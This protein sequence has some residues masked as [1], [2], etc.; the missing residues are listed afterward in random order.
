MSTKT[1]NAIAVLMLLLAMGWVAGAV[2]A[3]TKRSA[4]QGPSALAVLPDQSVWI[5]VEDAMWHLDA[6]GKR[7]KVVDA[8]ALGVGGMIGNLVVHPNGQLVAQTRSDPTLY[9]LDAETALIKS[10]L[11]PQWQA[12]LERHG[13]DAINYAFHDDGRVA[14]ATGGGHAVALF[15]AQGHFLART[16]PGTYEFANGLW[17]VADTLW[18][19]DTNRQELVELDGNT[20]A[21]KSR[22]PL[23]RNCGGFQYLGFAAPSHGQPSAETKS[24]PLITL[25]RFANGM[26]KGRASD[27]FSDGS[28]LD[29]PA[30]STTEPRDIKWRANELLMVDGDNYSIKRY[31]D[32]RT[33]LA[34]F[35]DDAVQAEL[36]ASQEQRNSLQKQYNGYLAGAVIFFIIG[37]VFAFRAQAKGKAEALADLKV[38]MSQLETPVFPASARITASLMIF[39]PL[40]LPIGILALTLR[41][42]RTTS[43]FIHA[44]PQA[45]LIIL[46]SLPAMFLFAILGVRW[47][48]RRTQKLPIAE[49]IYNQRAIQFL[50]TEASFWRQ[51]HPNE[52][53]QETLLL[54]DQGRGL[55]WLVLS[56]QRLFVYV[57]NLRDRTL[58][59][60]YLRSEIIGLRILERNE[61][62]W[63]QK[64]QQVF[65]YI[66]A[67]IRIDFKDGSSL[68]G[69]AP[70][71]LTA[72]R[73]SA[74]LQS[75]DE[76]PS[77]TP[78]TQPQPA[79]PEPRANAEQNKQA[80]R[81]TIASFLI[82][83]LGQ[84][85][86]GRSGTA[87]MY[88]VVW[89]VL[90]TLALFMG[91]TLWKAL[92]TVS[93]RS[94]FTLAVYYF[95]LCGLAAL[96]TWRMREHQ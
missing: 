19:T 30:T 57:A 35:G 4:I 32:D 91:W 3:T 14:I 37:F 62:T 56:N 84:W 27:I 93:G 59:H 46:I 33:P 58:A 22:V 26:T 74:V 66:G 18:T 42:L 41:L 55:N 15:D 77:V 88:F 94:I 70:S 79:Q 87:L 65:S 38:D 34:D 80:T 68:T 10:R 5:S 11:V 9:F 54:L 40:I 64:L 51:L 49:A 85:M 63:M 7:L 72:Q 8:A 6:N 69:R 25:I 23:S 31:A 29:F 82:P 86:Q 71:I 47:N 67:T 92:S 2:S 75:S 44:S 1:L 36:S 53:P 95:S 13:S 52:L 50:K 43:G 73:M 21:E 48:I 78:T 20:L 81:Q 12:D 45:L 61:M 60:E 17:W 16:N 89:L 24:A 39:W 90:I 76:M 96:D 28:Q 83:G